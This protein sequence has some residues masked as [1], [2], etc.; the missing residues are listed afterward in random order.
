M[1]TILQFTCTMFH[2]SDNYSEC[3]ILCIFIT[4]PLPYKQQMTPNIKKP[5]YQ[6]H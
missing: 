4:D 3:N 6:C 5:E 2:M 1:F